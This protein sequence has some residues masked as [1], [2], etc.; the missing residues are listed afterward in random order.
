[1]KTPKEKAAELVGKYYINIPLRDSDN[2]RPHNL[3]LIAVDECLHTCVESMIYLSPSIIIC[4]LEKN[5]VHLL[6]YKILYPTDL[7]N[8]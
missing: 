3:A 5:R 4:L 1:M 7:S 2:R 8:R 6:D